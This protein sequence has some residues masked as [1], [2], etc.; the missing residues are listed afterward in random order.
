MDEEYSAIQVLRPSQPLAWIAAVVAIAVSCGAAFYVEPT[1]SEPLRL[2]LYLAVMFSL[3]EGLWRHDLRP[4]LLWN[5]GGLVLVDSR[6][7]HLLT[8]SEVKVISVRGNKISIRGPSGVIEHGFDRWWLLAAISR[9]VH[10]LP[11]TIESS[12][13][14]AQERGLR[15]SDVAPPP[16]PRVRRPWILHVVAAVEFAATIGYRHWM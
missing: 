16:V 13:R 4:R 9:R 7:T 12:L 6:R 8:W 10:D 15:R 5:D 14:T 3:L 1:W 2:L 11:T